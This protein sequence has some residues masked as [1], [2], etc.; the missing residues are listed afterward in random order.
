MTDIP[1]IT[2]SVSLTGGREDSKPD[3][4]HCFVVLASLFY[5]KATLPVSA[6]SATRSLLVAV[7][8]PPISLLSNNLSDPSG[9]IYVKLRFKYEPLVYSK[10]SLNLP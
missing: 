6:G 1:V 9:Y 5:R 10:A 2:Y 8:A 7:K 3:F 4:C